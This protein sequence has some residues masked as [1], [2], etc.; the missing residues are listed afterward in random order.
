MKI[1]R[2]VNKLNSRIEEKFPLEILPADKQQGINIWKGKRIL[3]VDD[4]VKKTAVLENNEVIFDLSKGFDYFPDSITEV[5]F[6]YGVEESEKYY[7]KVQKETFDKYFNDYL[8]LLAFKKN[9]EYGSIIC[10]NCLL[11][12]TKDRSGFLIGIHKMVAQVLQKELYDDSDD[13]SVNQSENLSIYPCNVRNYFSCPYEGKG[14]DKKFEHEFVSDT[15]YLF[16][17]DQITHLVDISLL[18][19]SS[20]TKSNETVFEMDLESNAMKEVQTLYDGKQHVVMIWSP[21]EKGTH[22]IR[23]Q[24][25]LPIRNK[26]DIIEVLEDQEKIDLILNQ[27]LSTG[28]YVAWKD[29]ILNFFESIKLSLDPE[30]R[31]KYTIY[32]NMDRHLCH[33]CSRDANIR[34]SSDVTKYYCINHGKDLLRNDLNEFSHLP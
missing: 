8:D 7:K 3:S 10:K 4:W 30:F 27:G 14:K 22:R 18:K 33:K 1:D 2:V 34:I 5:I 32:E 29:K 23:E 25:V 28:D 16:N 31:F 15:E 19:A 24:S 12:P 26:E 6:Q 17:L 21:S 9:P 11:D 13:A 20:M